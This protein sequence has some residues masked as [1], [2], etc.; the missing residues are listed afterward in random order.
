MPDGFTIIKVD[1]DSNQDLRQKYGVT[2]QTTFVKVDAD[3]NGTGKYVAYE[4]PTF[5]AV[6]RNFLL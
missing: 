2:L 1:Y 3:G 6:K 4:E 5:E